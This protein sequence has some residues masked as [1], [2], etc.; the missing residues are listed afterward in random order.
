MINAPSGLIT[1]AVSLYQID[2]SWQDNSNNEDGFE[3]ERS[4]DGVNYALLSTLNVDTTTYSDPGPFLPF[5][6]Y[7]YR[8]R[9]MNTIGDRSEWSNVVK[10]MTLIPGWS[11]IA[12][13]ENHSLAITTN[14][15]LWTW[16]YNGYG[17]LGLGDTTYSSRYI[18]SLVREDFNYEIFKNIILVTGGESHSIILK[19]NGT[20]WGWGNSPFGQLGIGDNGTYNWPYLIGTDSD[21]IEISAGKWHTLARKTNNTIWSCGY[22]NSGEL[23]LGDQTNRYTPNQIGTLSNWAQIAAGYRHSLARKINGTIYSWGKNSCGELGLGDNQKRYNP[24]QIGINSDWI[25]VTAGNYFSICRKINGTL[26]AWGW[27]NYGQLG[28]GDSGDVTNRKT[29]SSIGMDSDW[30][31]IAAGVFHTI[32]LKTNSTLW[33]WGANVDRATA[34]GIGQ[35]GLGDTINR[36]TPSQVGADSDW[37]QIAAGSYHTIALKTNRI[38]WA[39]G[40]NS[41]GQLGFGDIVLRTTPTTVGE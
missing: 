14:G 10:T 31:M 23:G 16:G 4:V 25:Q 34:N 36:K 22:N 41:N 7:Y 9:A 27:N 8:V 1:T 20:L 35:L 13:G 5:T 38:L 11:A 37:S 6:T 21:W 26:W 19:T 32:A 39:W 2:L 33:A 18:P 12:A 29:P 17:Q 3:I 30:S 40:Y 15:F 24:T 28:L